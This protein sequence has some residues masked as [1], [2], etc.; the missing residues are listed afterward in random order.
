[1]TVFVVCYSYDDGFELLGAFT[2][3][4]P[5]VIEAEQA[6]LEARDRARET[7]SYYRGDQYSVVEVEVEEA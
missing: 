5:A 3:E 6:N 7:G 2:T 1:M 4:E